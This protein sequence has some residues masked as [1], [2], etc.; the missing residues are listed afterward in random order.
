MAYG[1]LNHAVVYKLQSL[2]NEVF[3]TSHE[4]VSICTETQTL[5]IVEFF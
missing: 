1:S 4:I 2:L 5:C 3:K